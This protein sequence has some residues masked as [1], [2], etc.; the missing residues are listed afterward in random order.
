VNT[1]AIRWLI[2]RRKPG[3]TAVFPSINGYF[4]PLLAVYEP[5]ARDCLE[6]AIADGEFSLQVLPAVSEVVKAIPPR[7][8][9][10]CWFN[11]NEPSDLETVVKE[12]GG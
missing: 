4:E 12:S 11:A 6:A 8:L 1:R 7:G 5:A 2:D 3:S 9:Q 10:R